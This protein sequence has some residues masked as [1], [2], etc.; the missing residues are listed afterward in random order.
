MNLNVYFFSHC[1]SLLSLWHDRHVT[2]ESQLLR[3]LCCFP[4]P[5]VATEDW[6]VMFFSFPQCLVLVVWKENYQE[7]LIKHTHTPTNTVK[8]TPFDRELWWR[9]TSADKHSVDDCSPCCYSTVIIL[10]FASWVETQQLNDTVLIWPLYLSPQW[11]WCLTPR[12]HIYY[13]CLIVHP[14][15]GLKSPSKPHTSNEFYSEM[16]S[17]RHFHELA[18]SI[19]LRWS[20]LFII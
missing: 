16:H 2:N 7:T 17:I 1:F 3:R 10:P 6:T 4:C 12:L 5:N 19:K 9:L 11:R 14:L 13:H 15:W 18:S 8:A 20:N